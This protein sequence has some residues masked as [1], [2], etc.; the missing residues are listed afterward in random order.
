[1]PANKKPVKS[2]L[3]DALD[4]AGFTEVSPRRGR[5]VRLGKPTYQLVACKRCG[6]KLGERCRGLKRNAHGERI[7]DAYRLT[8]REA[9]RAARAAIDAKP[10][11][12][13]GTNYIQHVEGCTEVSTCKCPVKTW[14]AEPIA[15]GL[16]T[17]S[18][19]LARQ[20]GAFKALNGET[21]P[22]VEPATAFAER[23]ARKLGAFVPLPAMVVEILRAVHERDKAIVAAMSW[24]GG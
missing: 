1:M 23:L 7:T 6:A 13:S 16:S 5:V 17:V 12:L 2:P 22:G 20:L 21:A 24:V 3:A 11:Q 15:P 14:P 19:E 18:V 4:A 10:R 9:G 8:A